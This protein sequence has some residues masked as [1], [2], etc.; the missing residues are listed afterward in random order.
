MREKSR[1]AL[2][3]YLTLKN[4]DPAKPDNDDDEDDD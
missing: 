1:F 4:L 2:K 3:R